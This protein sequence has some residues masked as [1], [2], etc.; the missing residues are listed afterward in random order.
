M[1][2]FHAQGASVGLAQGGDQPAQRGLGWS[3]QKGAGVEGPIEVGFLQ[4]EARRLQQRMAGAS[5]AQGV[6]M[7]QEMAPFA[8]RFDQGQDPH[9][10]SDIDGWDGRPCRSQ[11]ESFK[12]TTP[13]LVHRVG[14]L[15]RRW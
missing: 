9:L 3:P 5:L 1:H 8:I 4:A 14:I 11:L 2:V 6:E 7:S 12:K 10:G 13:A 15:A